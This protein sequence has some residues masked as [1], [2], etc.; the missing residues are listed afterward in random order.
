VQEVMHAQWQYGV[1]DT[2][3]QHVVGGLVPA[4]IM[5]A[6]DRLSIAVQDV[7]HAQWQ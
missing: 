3:L 4:H 5:A 2:A 7:M 6:C 1:I